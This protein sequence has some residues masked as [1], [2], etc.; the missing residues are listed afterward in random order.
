MIGIYAV[1]LD[2]EDFKVLRLDGVD[3]EAL[4]VSFSGVLSGVALPTGQQ[5]TAGSVPV[6]M[7]SDQ[8]PIGIAEAGA[9][10]AGFDSEAGATAHHQLIAAQGGTEVVYVRGLTV[11]NAATAPITLQLETDTGGAHTAISPAFPVPAGGSINLVFG[12]PGLPGA[13]NKNVGYSSVGASAFSVVANGVA[14]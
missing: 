3:I 4:P 6:T 12:G 1:S 14:R 2:G 9:A 10:V 5:N 7:A 13:A 11:F 8:P